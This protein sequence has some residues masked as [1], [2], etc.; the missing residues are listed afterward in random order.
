[1]NLLALEAILALLQSIRV[2]DPGMA[3][4][5]LLPHGLGLALLLVCGL[6]FSVSLLL[7]RP[8][9]TGLRRIGFWM[10]W[11]PTASW[12]LTFASTLMA[13]WHSPSRNPGA[14]A[15]WVSPDRGLRG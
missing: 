13:C 14:R 9:G 3:E 8:Y 10:I 7:D 12:L 2:L 4:A 5:H 11:Y 6:Q 15:R 1:V